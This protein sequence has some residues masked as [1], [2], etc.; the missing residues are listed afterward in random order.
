MKLSKFRNYLPLL[1]V[2]LLNGCSTINQLGLTDVDI[3][4]ISIKTFHTDSSTYKDVD[5][6]VY[7]PKNLNAA[8][9]AVILL[10]GCSGGHY[11]V[12]KAIAREVHARGGVTAVVDSIKTYGNQCRTAGTLSGRDRA[13]HAFVARDILVKRKLAQPNNVSVIGLSHGGWTAVHISKIDMPVVVFNALEYKQPF[14]SA[15]ALYPWCDLIST[16]GRDVSNPFLIIGSKSDDW[17]PIRRCEL[18]MSS[19]INVQIHAYETA[20]HAWDEP[21]PARTVQTYFGPKVIE[22]DDSATKDS[23]YRAKNFILKNLKF[24]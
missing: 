1:L 4:N 19:D 24:E 7:K 21:Y 12:H 22:Y 5:V 10:S 14:T 2:L 20:K 18:L 6:I 8:K 17:T 9:P 23:I 11:E 13:G 16:P 15:V 3:E